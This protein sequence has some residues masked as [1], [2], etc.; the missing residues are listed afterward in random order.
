MYLVDNGDIKKQ[1]ELYPKLNLFSPG[2]FHI[3]WQTELHSGSK[4]YR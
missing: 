4:Y 2:R 1:T 3:L